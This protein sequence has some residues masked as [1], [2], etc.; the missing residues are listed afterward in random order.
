MVQAPGT[1]GSRSKLPAVLQIA[2]CILAAAASV[3]ALLLPVMAQE[4]VTNSPGTEPQRTVE[5]L[6]LLQTHPSSILVPLAVPLILTLVPL[7]V[8]RRTAWVAAIVCTVLLFAFTALGMA[9]IGWLYLPAL[10][11]A[12]ASAV[13]HRTTRPPH[14]RHAK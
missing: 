11:A 13:L 9:T 6:T 2:A 7:L 14:N 10:V 12:T 8:P 5:S 1:H 4:T 3:S